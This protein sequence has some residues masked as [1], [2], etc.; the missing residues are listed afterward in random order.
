MRVEMMSTGF[1]L[2]YD[3]QKWWSSEAPP[4]Q[5]SRFHMQ[6]VYVVS[7]KT[8]TMTMTMT[9]TKDDFYHLSLFSWRLKQ[10]QRRSGPLISRVSK[11]SRGVW[12]KRLAYDDFKVVS[13]SVSTRTG[14]RGTF[15][16]YVA[17]VSLASL[18]T[19][20]SFFLQNDD[21]SLPL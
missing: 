12:F 21:H 4:V 5:E 3:Y 14:V 19:S 17:C 2:I 10:I 13:V 7:T 11:G 15:F 20:P 18:D 16:L 1:N 8:K 9:M 6:W